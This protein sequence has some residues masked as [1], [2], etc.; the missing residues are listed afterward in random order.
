MSAALHI[1]GHPGCW[2]H[3]HEGVADDLPLDLW[4]SGVTEQGT[5]LIAKESVTVHELHAG[6]DDLHLNASNVLTF[7]KV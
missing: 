6:I 5:L 7:S 4:V 2:G 3:G 1:L